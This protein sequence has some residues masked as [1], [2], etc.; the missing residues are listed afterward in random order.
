MFYCWCSDVVFCYIVLSVGSCVLPLLISRDDIVSRYRGVGSRVL[1][2]MRDVVTTRL[3]ISDVG[4][5]R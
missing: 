1:L 4:I 5:V 2:V 3:L